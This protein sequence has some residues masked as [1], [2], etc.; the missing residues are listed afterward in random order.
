LVQIAK[1]KGESTPIDD[2]IFRFKRTRM[3]MPLSLVQ[4]SLVILS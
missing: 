4:V 3:L 1:S 2:L